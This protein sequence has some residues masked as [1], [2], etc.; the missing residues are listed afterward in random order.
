MAIRHIVY[1]GSA[2]VKHIAP[3]MARDAFPTQIPAYFWILPRGGRIEEFP[4]VRGNAD[5]RR[6]VGKQTWAAAEMTCNSRGGHL[7]TFKDSFELFLANVRKHKY[8]FNA[9]LVEFTGRT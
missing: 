1:H 9:S 6:N 5:P 2:P 3:S 8:P 4:E 7:M